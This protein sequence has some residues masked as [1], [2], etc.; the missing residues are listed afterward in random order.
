MENFK[1]KREIS[2]NGKHATTYVKPIFYNKNYTLIGA[3]LEHGRTHQIRIHLSSIGHSLVGDT[4]Y[5]QKS[6]LIDH[7][8]LICKKVSF[9]H[10]Y[11]NKTLNFEIDYPNDFKNLLIVTGLK[12]TL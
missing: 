11:L 3:K 6:N 7:T 2:P 10:P 9:F 5:S 1:H 4:L 8:A 12:K